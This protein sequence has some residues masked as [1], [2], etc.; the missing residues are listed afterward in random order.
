[1]YLHGIPVPPGRRLG[2]HQPTLD[3]PR[4]VLHGR[5]FSILDPRQV[6]LSFGILIRVRCDGPIGIS[7]WCI[8]ANGKGEGRR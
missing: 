6:F 7:L 2:L 1:M 5:Q 8:W 4:R 3:L